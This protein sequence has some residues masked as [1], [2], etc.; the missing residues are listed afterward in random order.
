MSEDLKASCTRIEYQKAEAEGLRT[1]LNGLKLDLSTLKEKLPLQN[2]NNF[3]SSAT[4]ED[5]F[6]NLYQESFKDVADLAKKEL[7]NVPMQWLV[8]ELFD[9]SVS[10]ESMEALGDLFRIAHIDQNIAYSVLSKCLI[11]NTK[12]EQSS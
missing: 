8:S 2:V 11:G 5:D 7:P 9:P 10:R 4:I 12:Q 1:E 6:L 3:F